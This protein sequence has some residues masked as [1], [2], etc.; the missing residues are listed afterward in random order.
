[1]DASFAMTKTNPLDRSPEPE[2][3]ARAPRPCRVRS[4]GGPYVPP[5]LDRTFRNAGTRKMPRVRTL[6]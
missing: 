4:P 5:G 6:T 3:R 1:M 2:P